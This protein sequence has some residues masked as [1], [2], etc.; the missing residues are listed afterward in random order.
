MANWNASEGAE[1]YRVD[2]ARDANFESLVSGYE[3][4]DAGSA[5]HYTFTDLEPDTRYFYRVRSIAGPRTSG[6]SEVAEVTTLAISRDQ[7]VMETE[8]L[9]VLANGQQSNTVRSEEHTSELQSRGQL[10]CRLLLEK[11]NTARAADAIV[12]GVAGWR[13]DIET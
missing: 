9:R 3:N 4:T 8:Q 13:K 12:G 2:L 10:V 5:T 6:S 11:K 7:S 1:S